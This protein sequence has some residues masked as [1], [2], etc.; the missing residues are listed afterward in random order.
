LARG[1]RAEI[2]GRDVAKGLVSTI[3]KMK[4]ETVVELIPALDGWIDVELR[5]ERRKKHPSESRLIAL[6]DRHECLQVFCEDKTTVKEV[7][8]RIETIFTDSRES[9][10]IK[11]SSVHKAKGL[12][13][14]RVFILQ[15]KGSGMPHPMAK[16][17]W[18]KEQEF[19]LLY[20]AITRAIEE[21]VYV[22]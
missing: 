12:E 4:C 13:A 11:L 2:Q 9:T 1:R 18:Q 17:A 20:V 19:N 7:I 15:P 10:A 21:L 6:T 5:K 3:K 22:S 14:K 8:E 16:T